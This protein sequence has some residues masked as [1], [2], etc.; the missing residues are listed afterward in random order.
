MTPQQPTEPE[1]QSWSS[2]AWSNIEVLEIGKRQ[3]RVI[4]AIVIAL[5]AAGLSI[6]IPFA[7]FVCSLIP[8]INLVVLLTVSWAATSVLKRHGVRVGFLGARKDDLDRLKAA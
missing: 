2:I 3:R 8:I 1:S 6:Y 4:G 7:S 5:L